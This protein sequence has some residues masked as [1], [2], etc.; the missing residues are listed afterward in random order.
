MHKLHEI[1][2]PFYRNNPDSEKQIIATFEIQSDAYDTK[3]INVL[4][5]GENVLSRRLEDGEWK[6]SDETVLISADVLNQ[7]VQAVSAAIED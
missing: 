2:E 6:F 7:A 1:A 4:V 3:W 5:D